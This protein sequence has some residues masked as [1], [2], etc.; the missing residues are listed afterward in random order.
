MAIPKIKAHKYHAQNVE[1]FDSKKEY[2]RSKQLVFLLENKIISDLKYQVPFIL[3]PSQYGKDYNGKDICLRRDMKYI[4]DFTYIDDNG[5][6]I[7]EDSKGYKTIEYKRKRKL[8]KA[9]YNIEIKET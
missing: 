7:V 6:Y 4:A 8:M 5:K 9:I 2:N 3:C 1:G